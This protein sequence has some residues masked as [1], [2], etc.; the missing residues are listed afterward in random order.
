MGDFIH[1]STPRGHGAAVIPHAP[2]I[3]AKT[4]VSGI[5]LDLCGVQGKHD[6]HFIMR[7]MSKWAWYHISFVKNE[8]DGRCASKC[9]GDD[10]NAIDFFLIY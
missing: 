6:Y 3:F 4:R 9:V 8:C 10:K 1:L 7:A 2:L 5:T